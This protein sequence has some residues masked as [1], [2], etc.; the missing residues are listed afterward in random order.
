MAMLDETL[1]APVNGIRIAYGVA[2]RGFPLLFLHGF[3][4][5]RRTWEQITPT[6]AERFTLVACD[7]R[8]YGDSDRPADLGTM[9]NA[10][11]ASDHLALMDQL[12]LKE[13][14]V[15]G[16]DKG[17]SPARRLALEH[18]DRVKGLIILDGSP[19]GVEVARPRDPSGRQWYLDFFRQRQVAEQLIGQNPRLFFSLF[20]DRNPHLSPEEHEY[21]VNMFCRRGTVDTVLADYRSSA[22]VDGPYWREVATSGQK[23]R[24]PVLAL[25]GTRG[26][27]S[28]VPVL[29]AWRKVAETAE[30]EPVESG[31]YVHEEQPGVVSRRIRAFAE[32]LAT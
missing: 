31:H 7:R 1:Y 11:I 14:V 27:N 13:F 8:G 21:Y 28:T 22:E 19:E 32:S 15:I 6:L 29:E 5:T 2:G 26:P 12:G 25:W 10:T 18:P 20:L 9:N 23:M 4:R 30:G 16:H 24:V 17:A 3:P